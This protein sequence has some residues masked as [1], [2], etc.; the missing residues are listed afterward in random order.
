MSKFL[1]ENIANFLLS[2]TFRGDKIQLKHHNFDQWLYVGAYHAF[3]R[4]DIMANDPNIKFK[5][6]YSSDLTQRENTLNSG[7]HFK[8]SIIYMWPVPSAQMFETQVKRYLKYFIHPKA[9]DYMEIG[10]RDIEKTEVIWGL[11]LYTLVKIIRLII[12]KHVIE[13]EFVQ[14]SARIRRIFKDFMNLPPRGFEHEGETMYANWTSRQNSIRI[15]HLYTYAQNNIGF[16]LLIVPASMYRIFDIDTNSYEGITRQSF[17]NYVLRDWG[18]NSLDYSL[19]NKP[20]SEDE[21]NEFDL[22]KG[23][24]TSAYFRTGGTE[25]VYPCQILGFGKGP[26]EGAFFIMWLETAVDDNTVQLRDGNPV[27]HSYNPSRIF[28]R[29][30]D[31]VLNTDLYPDTFNYRLRL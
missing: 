17:Y 1:F 5:I 8:L 16:Q 19:R 2:E 11:D 9:F 29:P 14:C 25:Y 3:K 27:E 23:D 6:G 30:S 7:T 26:Y 10:N 22:Y 24:F 18:Q 20:L 21:D 12:L 13:Q 15:E 31:I 28:I 4:E